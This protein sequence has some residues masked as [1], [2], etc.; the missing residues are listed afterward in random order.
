MGPLFLAGFYLF[1]LSVN[2]MLL[3]RLKPVTPMGTRKAAPTLT[4]GHG[5]DTS[6]GAGATN[7]RGTIGEPSPIERAPASFAALSIEV[8][9][10]TLTASKTLGAGGAKHSFQL[11]ALPFKPV[12]LAWLHIN[13]SVDIVSQHSKGSHRRQL[14]KEISG[15]AAPGHMTA[16]MG[17]SG[18]GKTTLMVGLT[19]NLPTW[20]NS[21][22]MPCTLG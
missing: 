8:Q 18:A 10:R 17:S 12:T 19:A 5:H 11:S 20:K 1:F 22:T 4:Y 2:T 14:L 7:E 6:A 16:L 21:A 3:G 13:Y 15:F 9:P